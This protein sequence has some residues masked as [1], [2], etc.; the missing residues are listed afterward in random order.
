[1]GLNTVLTGIPVS[2]SHITRAESFPKSAVTTHF[3]SL[4]QAV[5]V[6]SLHY[7][8]LKRILHELEG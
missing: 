2:E 8:S 4:E 5:A 7:E 6:I 1:L 3:L